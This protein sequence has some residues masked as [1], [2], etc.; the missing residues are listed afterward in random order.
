MRVLT[1]A[2]AQREVARTGQEWRS[3]LETCGH[4]A[5]DCC[6][7]LRLSFI[8]D[9]AGPWEHLREEERGK[10]RA[11]AAEVIRG[12][13]RDA[14]HVY[15]MAMNLRVVDDSQL[16]D[17]HWGQAAGWRIAAALAEFQ[18]VRVVGGVFLPQ[19]H[20]NLRNGGEGV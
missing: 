13:A 14:R 18:V 4:A 16:I 12:E 8:G 19:V 3:L 1:V 9:D 20:G 11:R 5:Y 2:Q 7:S 6:R 15:A 10:W 17:E